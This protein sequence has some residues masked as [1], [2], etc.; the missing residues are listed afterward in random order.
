MY[1]MI[2]DDAGDGPRTAAEPCERAHASGSIR[3]GVVHPC[4]P[5]S[6]RAAIQTPSDGLVEA[7]IVAPE[8]R[9][10]AL[11]SEYGRDRAAC[12]DGIA[13]REAEPS[14]REALELY[15]RRIVREIGAMAALLGGLDLLVFTA[16]IGAHNLTIRARICETLGF[17][18]VRIDAGRNARGIGVI[19]TD[20]SV[21]TVLVEPTN[22]EWV[23]ARDAQSLLASAAG[24][25]LDESSRESPPCGTG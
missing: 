9:I 18:G 15:A 12:C 21:A 13:L 20:A 19:S 8:R 23:V 3:L 6:L 16:G 2:T 25:I 1:P 5:N 14:A 7:R 10:A 11:A 17:L 24:A 22:E 4:D